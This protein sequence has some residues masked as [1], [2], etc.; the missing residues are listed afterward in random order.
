MAMTNSDIRNRLMRSDACPEVQ[1]NERRGR[2]DF[3]CV[4]VINEQFTH[5][6]SILSIRNAFYRNLKDI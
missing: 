5:V 2:C 6:T 4:T 3:I 1:G